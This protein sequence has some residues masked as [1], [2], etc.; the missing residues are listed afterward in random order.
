V[1]QKLGTAGACLRCESRTKAIAVNVMK[2]MPIGKAQSA[3]K[4]MGAPTKIFK[5]IK[6]NSLYLKTPSG[7]RPSPTTTPRLTRELS[8][9]LAKKYA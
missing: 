7:K 9:I 8:S 2:E 6:I 1:C 3:E 4:S 5:F